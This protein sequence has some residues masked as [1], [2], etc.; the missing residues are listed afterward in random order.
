[1]EG[2]GKFLAKYL[3]GAMGVAKTAGAA[4]SKTVLMGLETSGIN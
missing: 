4:F 1:M 3:I 2:R